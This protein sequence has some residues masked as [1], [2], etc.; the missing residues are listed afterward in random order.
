MFGTRNASRYYNGIS[1]TRSGRIR[2][3]GGGSG[4]NG[5]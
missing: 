5:G 2:G 3:A 4:S 1:Y